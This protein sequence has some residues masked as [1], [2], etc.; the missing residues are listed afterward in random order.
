MVYENKQYQNQLWNDVKCPDTKLSQIEKLKYTVAD[1][2]KHFK[3]VNNCNG[4]EN[5]EKK[6]TNFEA[7]V[8]KGKFNLKVAVSYNMFNSTIEQDLG[9]L[10]SD[11]NESSVGFGLE[12]EYILPTNKNK[13]SVIFEPNYNSFKGSQELHGRFASDVDRVDVKYVAIQLPV[14]FRYYMFLN[15]DSKLFLTGAFAVNLLSGSEVEYDRFSSFSV[16]PTVYNFGLG[17]GYN[18]KR[19][20]FEIRYYT[21]HGLNRNITSSVQKTTAILRYSFF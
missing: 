16:F 19:F 1:L 5:T 3:E 9:W 20:N 21:P 14:G 17:A 15:N 7:K 18:Y 10:S 11:I 8:N 6:T 13:W 12:V 2:I 4:S